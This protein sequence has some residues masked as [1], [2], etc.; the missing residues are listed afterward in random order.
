MA[1]VRLTPTER[2]AVEEALQEA[3]E[4]RQQINEA[5]E[6]GLQSGEDLRRVDTEIARAEATLKIFG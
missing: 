2:Q 4:L 5:V 3:K 1:R 6:A